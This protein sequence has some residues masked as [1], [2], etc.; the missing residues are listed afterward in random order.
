VVPLRAVRDLELRRK[1]AAKLLVCPECGDHG[2]LTAP[3]R[4]AQL[5]DEGAA[6]ELELPV[7]FGDPL[8]FADSVP[9]PRR[10]A[11]AREATGLDEA[12]V[13]VRGTVQGR[14]MICAV[15]DFRFLGG[16]V[17]A[18][19]GDLLTGAAETALRERTPFVMVTASGG[20][21]MQEGAI[22]LMQMARISAA[23]GRLDAAGVLTITVITDPTFGGV[24]ASFATL[25][26]I[27]LAEPG[28]RLGFAGP[29]ADP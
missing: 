3:Q 9:Y 2:R 13:C 1:A 25:G 28:A 18:A 12:V 22:A 23:L 17:G 14:R 29:R 24:A 21:R 16:S 8:R 20:A 4:I 11:D 7:V 26:D 27:I 6:Q 15:M 5:F 10:L 19:T